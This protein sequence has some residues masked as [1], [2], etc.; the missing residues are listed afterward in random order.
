MYGYRFALILYDIKCNS[1]EHSFDHFQDWL[2]ATL[3]ANGKPWRDALLE[4]CGSEESALT[5]FFRL[6][7][8][9]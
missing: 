6:T 9:Y 8:E 4:K 1:F 3:G 2:E 7:D 5:E